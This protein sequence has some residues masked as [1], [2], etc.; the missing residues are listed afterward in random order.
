MRKAD[1]KET[2]EARVARYE[3]ILD[4]AA[5]AA[6]QAEKALEDY[7]RIL[8][9]LRE[10]ETYYTGPDWKEDYTADEAGLFPE[11]MKRGVLSQDAVYDLLERYR[12]IRA[13]MAEYGR[14]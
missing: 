8:P 12:E 3:A 6:G 2:R 1:G 11:G 7:E 4:N 9:A 13:R 14:D 5:A 10:L